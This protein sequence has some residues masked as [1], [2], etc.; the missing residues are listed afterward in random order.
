MMR[1]LICFLVVLVMVVSLLGG[2]DARP[3]LSGVACPGQK[4]NHL[5]T[6]IFRQF[7]AMLPK[8]VPV[9]P[10]GPNPGINI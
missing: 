7:G 10:S 3:L 4:N 1:K 5:S 2:L 9:P 6:E 8:G